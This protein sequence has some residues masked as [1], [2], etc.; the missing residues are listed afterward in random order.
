ML[1]R[2]VVAGLV[3]GLVLASLYGLVLLATRGRGATMPLA[4]F[5]A[6]GGI[7]A[8]ALRL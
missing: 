1:G 4:P 6:A 3:A 5:L 7:A 2:Y 8:L